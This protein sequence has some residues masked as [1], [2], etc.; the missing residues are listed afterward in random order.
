MFRANKGKET[1]KKKKRKEIAATGWLQKDKRDEETG[2]KDRGGKG[3]SER[4]SERRKEWRERLVK[5]RRRK[6]RWWGARGRSG[7]SRFRTERRRS[8]SERNRLDRANSVVT[9]NYKCNGFFLP[10][11]VFEPHT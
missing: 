10:V 11:S 2:R 8:E 3:A 7:W 4:A 5:E 9:L 1:K 6:G